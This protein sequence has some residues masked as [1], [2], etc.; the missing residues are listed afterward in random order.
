MSDSAP[1]RPRLKISVSQVKVPQVA[2]LSGTPNPSSTNSLL[3]PGG[4][5]RKI[6]FKGSQPNTPADGPLSKVSTPTAK[7]KAGRQ[8][9][10]TAKK[11]EHDEFGE[12]G[13][14]I[15]EQHRTKKRVVKLVSSKPAPNII[16]R[17]HGRP[18]L[19]PPG[20]GYDSEASDREDDPMVEE[21]VVLRMLPGEHCNYI[22]QSIEENKFGPRR[23]GGA[24]IR[25]TWLEDESRR[26]I[27]YV[28]GQA[29]VAVLVDLPTITEGMK[30]F[31]RK[32]CY[33]STDICQMLLVFQQVANETEAKTVPLPS[34]VESGFKWPHG[35]TPPMH[36]CVK[37]RFAKVISRK[38]IEDKEAEVDRLLR[39]DADAQTSKWELVDDRQLKEE[40][41]DL[42][43]YEEDA[44]GEEDDVDYFQSQDNL[45]ATSVADLEADLEAAF[46]EA[47]TPATQQDGATPMT[48]N[49]ITPVAPI[50]QTVEDSEASVEDE[51][52]DDD[53]DD[54]DDDGQDQA[55]MDE[56]KGVRA[57]IADL[58]AQLK[59]KEDDLKKPNVAKSFL[60]RKRVE[61]VIRTLKSE[62]QLKR[63]AIGEEE[64]EEEEE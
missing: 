17:P 42:V 1:Q 12:D 51:D 55:E 61:E 56:V 31:D 7:T 52:E 58:K 4:H 13:V 33:K 29:Y 53:E 63:S 49:A 25:L 37:R 21:Q 54:D 40:A 3:T 44:E 60:L 43:E 30:T 16:I 2:D 59:M 11:R 36:D 35:L 15:D 14:A 32:N 10:P 27:L 46:E 6:V 64:E 47:S 24:D 9:K 48:A 39:R 23:D 26:A 38:E 5:T 41:E 57:M 22:R 45:D 19:R 20:E 28:K 50:Q 62:I 34:I 18:P 8:T